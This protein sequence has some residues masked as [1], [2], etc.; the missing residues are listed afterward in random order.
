MMLAVRRMK[1]TRGRICFSHANAS[2]RKRE[3]ENDPESKNDEAK[4]R[5]NAKNKRAALKLTGTPFR[6]HASTEHDANAR[7]GIPQVAFDI[8]SPTT[9]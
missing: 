1:Q 9:M 8:L 7:R 2:F 6:P 5:A 4:K 3:V